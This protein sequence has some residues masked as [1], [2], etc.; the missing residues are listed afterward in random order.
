MNPLLIFK[1]SVTILPSKDVDDF[2]HVHFAGISKTLNTTPSDRIDMI[3]F[4]VNTT[5]SGAVIT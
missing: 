1:G 5:S 3:R 4:L 2:T